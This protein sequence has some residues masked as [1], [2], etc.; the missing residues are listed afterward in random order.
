MIFHALEDFLDTSLSGNGANFV[1][2]TDLQVSIP[3]SPHTLATDSSKA[4]RQQRGIFN[5][6]VAALQ[7]LRQN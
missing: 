4:L 6:I 1:L 5:I 3:D 7:S 2:G